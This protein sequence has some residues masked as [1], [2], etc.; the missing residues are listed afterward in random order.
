[1]KTVKKRWTTMKTMKMMNDYLE[2]LVGDDWIDYFNVEEY[3]YLLDY[4]DEE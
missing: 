3:E 4:L 2:Q 1:M